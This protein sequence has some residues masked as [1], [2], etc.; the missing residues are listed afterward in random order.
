MAGEESDTVEITLKTIGPAR[1]TRLRVPGTIKIKDLRRLVAAEFRLPEERLKLVLK[2]KTL[3]ERKEKNDNDG[4]ALIRLQNGDSLI[5]A[6]VPKPPA[7]YLQEADD[8]DDEDL[9]F[10]IPQST[11]WLKK[12]IFLFLHEKLR[13]PDILLMAIFSISL[14]A[15]FGILIWFS[16]APVAQKW[17]IGPI[18]ILGTGF[19]IILLNLGKR[20]QGDASAYSIFNEDFRELPGTLNA[21]RLDRDIRAGQF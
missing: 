10:R 8:D 6:V 16:L 12:R 11:N 20:Q 3:Q 9:K 19:F 5:V 13:L 15:W 2:G 17:G 4:D 7:R 21:D 1:P 18:Y 14:K